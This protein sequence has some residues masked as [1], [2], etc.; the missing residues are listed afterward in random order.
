MSDKVVYTSLEGFKLKR[1]K[2]LSYTCLSE[3]YVDWVNEN[4]IKLLTNR[5]EA[6]LCAGVELKKYFLRVEEQVFFMLRG[7]SYFLDY[8]LPELKIAVEIDGKY[9]KSRKWEDRQRDSDFR[10]IGIKTIR[11]RS[12][13]VFKGKFLKLFKRCMIRMAKS[14]TLRR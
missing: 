10:E 5:N 1:W 6:E 4:T 3:E 12:T 9:H 2:V 13:D 8:Y 11:I 7:R 14:S